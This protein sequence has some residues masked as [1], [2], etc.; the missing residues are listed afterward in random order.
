[1]KYINMLI[2]IFSSIYT[3]GQDG[4][5]RII[6]EDTLSAIKIMP[7]KQQYLKALAH[8]DFLYVSDIKTTHL[9]FDEKVKYLDIGSPYF[10]A[11]TIK[12]MIKLK[13]IGEEPADRDK[14]KASNLTVI[15]ESGTYYSLA[16]TYLR[17]PEILTYK[18]KKTYEKIPFIWKEKQKEN[19]QRYAFNKLCNAIEL[20]KSDDIIK[21]ERDELKIKMTGVFYHKDYIAIRIE[22]TNMSVIDL[23]IDQILI[24][25]KLNKKITSDYLYQERTI[26]PLRICN[27]KFKIVGGEREK[28]TLIFEKFTP[29]ANEKLF[30]DVFEANGGR[31]VS[32]TL[33]RKKMLNPETVSL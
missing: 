31:S 27:K 5:D 15:T 22:L 24:R 16:M 17:N 7:V 28:M 13:H 29:N 33:P 20:G 25:S 8:Q 21:E 18:I 3:Y 30:I 19:E 2:I 11:D 10:V 4:F 14:S 23:D 9:I 1:M 6:Q 12:S 32:I 26:S